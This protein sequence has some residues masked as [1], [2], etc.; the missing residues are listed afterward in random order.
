[1]EKKYCALLKEKVNPEIS[2]KGCKFCTFFGY[3]EFYSGKSC[4][5]LRQEIEKASQK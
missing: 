5:H 3:T 2:G 4:K 1:M